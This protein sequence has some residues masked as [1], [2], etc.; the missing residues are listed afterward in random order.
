MATLV[1]SSPST[2]ATTSGRVSA[3][4]EVNDGGDEVIVA[5][6]GHNG[7]IRMSPDE[8]ADLTIALGLALT[9]V[10]GRGPSDERRD[11]EAHP[12]AFEWKQCTRCNHLRKTLD[13]ICG[14]CY[15]ELRA[16]RQ[17]AAG[18]SLS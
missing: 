13:D 1:I 16:E 10:S 15:D 11:A 18:P 2:G 12:I 5:H 6:V 9:H 8:A 14:D 3:E 4:H 17:A 7:A